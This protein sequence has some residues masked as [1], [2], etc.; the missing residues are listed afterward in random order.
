MA[1]PIKFSEHLIMDGFNYAFGISTVD[2]TGNGSLDIVA[3]DAGAG[4]YWFENDGQGHFTPHVIYRRTD[5]WLERHAIADIN[6]DGRPEI[7]IVDNWNGSVLY[8]A[9]EGD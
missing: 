3:A 7:V 4:L 8:F 5:Q 9:F 6:A 2:L 1:E